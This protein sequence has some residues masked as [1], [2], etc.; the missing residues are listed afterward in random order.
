[1]GRREM[2]DHFEHGERGD[3]RGGYTGDR[4][5]IGRI[6]GGESRAVGVAPDV[7]AGK[8][9]L[10][11]GPR[12]QEVEA[13][14]H[15]PIVPVKVVSNNKPGEALTNGT[16]SIYRPK[17]QSIPVQRTQTEQR[18]TAP[19]GQTQQRTSSSQGQTQQQ[20]NSSPQTQTQP[21]NSRPPQNL[22]APSSVTT[23][24]DIQDLHRQAQPNYRPSQNVSPRQYTPAPRQ[25]S[26]PV[27]QRAPQQ[28]APRGGGGGQPRGGA[29]GG[30]PK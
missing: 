22:P 5:V 4:G 21:R 2:R 28:S 7:D 20:G 3:G 19:Q 15:T 25:Q 10:I 12:R 26:A 29:G 17:A 30:R 24:K 11:T 6:R 8:R 13:I 27:Q 1:M 9:G 18:T 14:T 16:L 23:T